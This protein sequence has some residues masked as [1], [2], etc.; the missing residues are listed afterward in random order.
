MKT[1]VFDIS[2]ILEDEETIAAYLSAV[3]E[4]NDTKLLLK[5]IGHIAKARGMSKIA[6]ESGLGRESLYKALDENSQP[7]FETIMKVLN[8]MNVKMKFSVASEDNPKAIR[9]A[10]KR[11]RKKAA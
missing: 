1:T 3:I 9:S 8:A 4:E 2:E 7:R 11:V 6:K 10:T 5:A